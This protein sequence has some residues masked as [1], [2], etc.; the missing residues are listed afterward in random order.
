MTL[1]A[2]YLLDCGTLNTCLSEKYPL[3]PAPA[4]G[5]TGD[6]GKSTIHE[7]ENLP[8]KFRAKLKDYFRS[9]YDRGH[10]CVYLCRFAWCFCLL[11]SAVYHL[12]IQ[13]GHGL[14]DLVTDFRN[15]YPWSAQ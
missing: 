12:Q 9:E 6:R 3:E 7:D 4:D 13:S 14:K 11:Y 10:M 1:E 15:T 8:V 5:Y 2:L